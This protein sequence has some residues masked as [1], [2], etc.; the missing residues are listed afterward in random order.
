MHDTI[1]QIAVISMSFRNITNELGVSALAQLAVLAF[2]NRPLRVAKRLK[3][4]FG[5]TGDRALSHS[6]DSNTMTISS[7]HWPSTLHFFW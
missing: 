1:A 3:Q 7:F 4:H 6:Q 2:P 5:V